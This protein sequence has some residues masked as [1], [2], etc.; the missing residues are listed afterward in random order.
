MTKNAFIAALST[1]LAGLPAEDLQRSLEYYSE[2]IAKV[3]NNCKKM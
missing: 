1:K 2:Y 3:K